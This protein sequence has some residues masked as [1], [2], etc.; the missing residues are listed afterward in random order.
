M[1]SF[2]KKG[3]IYLGW[4]SLILSYLVQPWNSHEMWYSHYYSILFSYSHFYSHEIPIDIPI[5]SPFPWLPGD[6]S[7]THLT[8]PELGLFCY[9]LFVHTSVTPALRCMD[10]D[11][12]VSQTKSF[13]TS[14]TRLG[15]V[16]FQSFKV[17]FQMWKVEEFI[18]IFRKLWSCA[19]P[20]YFFKIQ[21]QNGPTASPLQVMVCIPFEIMIQ[22]SNAPGVAPSGARRGTSTS[23]I[24]WRYVWHDDIWRFP[25]MGIPN[26]WMVY[27][28]KWFIME[29]CL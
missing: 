5:I 9:R 19:A 27:N 14:K 29:N 13:E 17:W 2:K 26:F 22:W 10:R 18:L 15:N 1:H 28:G 23:A 8:L 21:L 25:K 3:C 6:F 4:C 7:R 24:W 16:W 12:L 11:G 20:L